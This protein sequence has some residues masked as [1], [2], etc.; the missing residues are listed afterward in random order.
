[1]TDDQRRQLLA[2]AYDSDVPRAQ[3]REAIYELIRELHALHV[4]LEN[5]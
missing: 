4:D 2:T 3:R 5:Q 1:V